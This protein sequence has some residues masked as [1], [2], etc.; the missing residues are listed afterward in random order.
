MSASYPASA[1]SFSALNVGDIIQDTQIEAAYDEIT[2]LE[3]ALLSTGLAHPLTPDASANGRTLGSTSK[4]WGL[5]YLKGV[6]FADATEL[7]IATGAIAA[8]QS[9]HKID[10][11]SDAAAD[12][13][14]TIAAGAGIV[15]GS[16]LVL[17][18]ENVAR[19]VTVKDGTGN[20]LLS[21]DCALS[22]TDRTL[23]LLYDGTNWRELARS[24]LSGA[25]VTPTFAAGN[26]TASGS[27]TWTLAAGDVGTYAYVLEGK[28][29]TVAFVLNTTTVGGTP[30]T[31]LRIAIPAGA[32]SAK[33][34]YNP[35]L[36]IDNNVRG[37]GYA[38]VSAAGTVIEITRTDAAN[39]TASTDLTYVFGEIRFEVQ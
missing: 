17:R 19:V 37:T 3:Q 20:L 8:T 29:M 31:G 13:L 6:A 26:F 11:E 22:A 27:M 7:T 35:V 5:S 34:M 32:V 16:V 4:F 15:A 14:D 2:A 30:S 28:T 39:W 12:D 10:T 1:K 9:Y 38:A 36:I 24:V 23:T 21:G 18:A 25:W 33:P